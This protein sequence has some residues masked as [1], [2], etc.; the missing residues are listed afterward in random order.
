MMAVSAETGSLY[1]FLNEVKC[2]SWFCEK[3]KRSSII[4]EMIIAELVAFF[5]ELS[6]AFHEGTDENHKICSKCDK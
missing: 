3:E 6:L 4:N 1:T 5:I 2:W